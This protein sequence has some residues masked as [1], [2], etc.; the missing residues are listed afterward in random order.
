[1][2]T[3]LS[4]MEVHARLA[5][6]LAASGQKT[7]DLAALRAA[8][9]QLLRRGDHAEAI[10]FADRA[11]IIDAQDEATLTLRARAL[12]GSGKQADAVAMLEAL[13]VVDAGGE[14]SVLLVELYLDAGETQRASALAER[15][16][17]REPKHHALVQ[18]VAQALIER[19]E[20]ES[21]LALLQLVRAAVL[22]GGEHEHLSELL[23]RAAEALPGRVEPRELLVEV[24]RHT[25]DS[26][27]LPDALIN[28][29]EAYEA[30]GDLERAS[31]TYAQ[32]LE[33][34]P[35]NETVR[36]KQ[37]R[38][39]ARLGIG[40]GEPAVQDFAVTPLAI[41]VVRRRR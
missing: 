20:A 28:L 9:Q 3:G 13:P 30:A 33:R 24:F 35:E 7:E 38:L 27:R 25:S 40:G 15:V 36:R 31:Q 29:A 11:L 6:L 22:E 4:G 18:R 21:A 19:N 34:E 8:A 37:E 32:F 23:G 2:M 39:Q 17:A 12:V 5:E 16:F 26:F 10:Q 1:M 14:S 41:K